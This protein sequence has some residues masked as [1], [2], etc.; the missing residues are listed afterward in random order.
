METTELQSSQEA[1]E[2]RHPNLKQTKERETTGCLLTRT[3]VPVSSCSLSRKKKKKKKKRGRGFVK[4][5]LNAY[6]LK[7]N[8]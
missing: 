3:L 1:L 5:N 6:V 7:L 2:N 4:C 8:Y